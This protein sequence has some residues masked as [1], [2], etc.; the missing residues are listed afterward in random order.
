LAGK[1]QREP[2]KSYDLVQI[3]HRTAQIDRTALKTI[4]SMA[5]AEKSQTTK[6]ICS[7][8]IKTGAA[9]F[10]MSEDCIF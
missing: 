6:L 5:K 1:V 3:V 8:Q 7:Y 4:Q 10:D 2:V 9:P